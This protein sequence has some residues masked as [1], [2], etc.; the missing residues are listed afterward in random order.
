MAQAHRP[1][2]KTERLRERK[3]LTAVI[4]VIYYAHEQTANTCDSSLR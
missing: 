2:A 1:N 4:R 3:T